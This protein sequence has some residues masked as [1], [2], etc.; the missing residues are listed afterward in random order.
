MSFYEYVNF[1]ILFAQIFL[2]YLSLRSYF[3]MR[4]RTK[5]IAELYNAFST[6]EKMIEQ[7]ELVK[8]LSLINKEE[9]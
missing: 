2:M 4:K 5:Q 8:K 6:R 9:N 7:C 3:L 1:I